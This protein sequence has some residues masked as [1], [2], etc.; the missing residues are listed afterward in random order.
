MNK[1]LLVGAITIFLL[2][3]AVVLLVM[4]LPSLTR[5]Y[6]M[7]EPPSPP[8][9]P[10]TPNFPQKNT[11]FQNQTQI[12]NTQEHTRTAFVAIHLE[13]GSDA[14]TTERPAQYWQTLVNL[15]ETADEHN[16]TLTLMFNP[17][18]ATHILANQT[19]LDLL[20]SWEAEG[21]EI[22]AHHHSP[23]YGSS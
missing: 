18:W 8:T 4:V 17:Q 15:I 10:K 23:S 6:E 14:R 9:Y 7:N 2:I 20:R 22:A 13:P 5:P 19:K 3:L 21:H 16:V 12:L 1:F 11:T